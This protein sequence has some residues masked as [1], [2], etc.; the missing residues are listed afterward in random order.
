MRARVRSSPTAVDMPIVMLLYLLHRAQIDEY[1][2]A[3][4]FNHVASCVRANVNILALFGTEIPYNLC[5]N[6]EWQLCAAMGKLPGQGS[7]M[8]RFAVAPRGLQIDGPRGLGSCG[9]Y[10]P[11]GV[12]N[13]P[14]RGYASSD[15]FFLEVRCS[16][17]CLCLVR[18]PVTTVT[19]SQTLS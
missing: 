4:R 8:I 13:C 11:L 9:G 1:C 6:F 5:R 2:N 17:R 19:A 18:S 10:V 12:E 14:H 3:T 7:T 16:S 15:I